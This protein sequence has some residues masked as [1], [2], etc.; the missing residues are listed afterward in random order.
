LADP[1]HRARLAHN[2]LGCPFA[3]AFVGSE[4]GGD[5]VGSELLLE[6]GGIEEGLCGALT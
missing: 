5:R 3:L 2:A 6:A 4:S 1:T